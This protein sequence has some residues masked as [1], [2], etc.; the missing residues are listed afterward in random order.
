MNFI[1]DSKTKMKFIANEEILSYCEEI[2]KI[3][4]EWIIQPEKNIKVSYMCQRED[5]EIVKYLVEK[6][7]NIHA[8]NEDAII[9]AARN[10]HLE[11]VKYLVEKGA[12]LP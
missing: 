3:I 10:G 4:Y 8:Y 5:I 12:I 11:I 7:A 6:G 9:W 1:F 2:D